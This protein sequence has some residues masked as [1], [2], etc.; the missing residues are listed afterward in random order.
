[1]RA[2]NMICLSLIAVGLVSVAGVLGQET[3]KKGDAVKEELKRLEGT[4][5]AVAVEVGGKETDDEIGPNNL[6]VFSGT[7]LSSVI[8][9]NK[10]T[11]ECTYTI[12]PTKNPK[13][14]DQTRTSDKV[15]WHGIYEL[16]GDM[17]KVFL[18]PSGKRPTEFKTKEG[19]QQV[20]HT[21]ERV[22]P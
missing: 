12:D 20:I 19:T 3:P 10:R 21:L 5:R 9:V 7:K 22:K 8:G 13:W 18:G 17:L 1:M 16:K 11:I 6:L 4:W 15:A 14:I 2:M